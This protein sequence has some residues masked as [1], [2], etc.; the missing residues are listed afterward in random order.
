MQPDGPVEL[1]ALLEMLCTIESLH[2]VLKTASSK[3]FWR[4]REDRAYLADQG[5]V[6]GVNARDIR[7]REGLV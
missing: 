7:G 3:A 2:R 4:P 5:Q 1:V 6:R